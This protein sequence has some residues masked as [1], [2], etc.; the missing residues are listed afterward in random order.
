MKA[1]LAKFQANRMASHWEREEGTDLKKKKKL[2]KKW[3]QQNLVFLI[4]GI[5]EEKETR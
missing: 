1:T 2:L 4:G 5:R 3:N